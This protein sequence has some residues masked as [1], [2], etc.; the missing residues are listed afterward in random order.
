MEKGEAE[1]LLVDYL[2]QCA[3]SC[4]GVSGRNPCPRCDAPCPLYCPECCQIVV[5]RDKWPAEVRDNPIKLP[6]DLD[7]ILDDRRTSATGLQVATMLSAKEPSSRYRLYDVERSQELPDYEAEANTFL[8]FPG[9]SSRPVSQ[10]IKESKIDRI[11]V[12]DC[13]WA[14]SSIRLHPSIRKLPRVH[15]DS[16]PK[17]SYYWRWHTAGEG[18]LSTVEAV[19]FSS[20][21]VAMALNWSDDDRRRLVHLLYLFGLQRE[22]IRKNYEMRGGT[23]LPKHMPFSEDGK[24]YQRMLRRHS[25]GGQRLFPRFDLCLVP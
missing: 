4:E 8:L 6:F 16:H 12:L 25:T 19:Y 9:E 10:V 15:L 21:D 13:K 5:Q 1:R 2:E 24:E 7:L 22:I 23:G 18:M 11:V 17:H 20:W 3:R 14:S